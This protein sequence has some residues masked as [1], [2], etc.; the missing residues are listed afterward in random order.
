MKNIVGSA[1]VIEDGDIIFNYVDFYV[2]DGYLVIIGDNKWLLTDGRYIEHAKQKAKATCYLQSEVS[3]EQ[4]LTENQVKKVGLIYQNTS[5]TLLSRLV[6]VGFEVYDAIDIY[7]KF[8][9]VKSDV[10]LSK[11]KKACEITETAFQQTLPFIKEGVTELEVSA[12][13]EYN[14]KSLGGLVGFETIVAFGENSSVPH[15]KTSD[16]KLKP[17]TPILMDFGCSYQGYLSDMTRTFYF[18][19]PSDKFLTVYGE[20]KKAWESAYSQIRTKMSCVEADKIARSCLEKAGL[21]NYFTHSL[22]HG[23]GVKIHEFPTLSPKSSTILEDG[24]VFSIEPGVYLEREFGV[25]IEDTV[26]LQNGSCKS[27]MKSDKNPIILSVK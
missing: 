17:N 20:V 18:G 27:L 22:G 2:D 12:I 16:K 21:S 8:S 14:F 9:S 7:Q 4:L 11:I 26:V 1:L 15:Y 10:Q 23:I 13:L 3:L 25:R 6:N 5:A 24:M 19:E